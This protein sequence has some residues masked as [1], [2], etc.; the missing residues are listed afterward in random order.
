MNFF[1]HIF[2]EFGEL[3]QG[4]FLQPQMWWL[5]APLLLILIVL[6]IYFA[7]HQKERLG[8]N[9]ALTNSALLFFV[10]VDLLKFIY[11]YTDPATVDNFL[12]HPYK[13][14]VII[15]IMVEGIILS[16][17]AFV[18]ALPESFMF[19][20]ASPL[21]I[22]VQAYVL[23]VLVYLRVDPTRYTFF[24]TLLLFSTL[25]IISWYISHVIKKNTI[26]DMNYIEQPLSIPNPT[27]E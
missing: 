4:P 13:I 3:V 24:A 9:T 27:G 6:T 19:F 14:L 11:N 22:N 7:T 1:K 2:L 26:K 25:Y 15:L 16:Y 18:H 12:N 20:I 8:W 5:V 23:I 10:G 17:S 21:F